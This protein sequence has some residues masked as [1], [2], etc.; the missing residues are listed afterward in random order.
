MEK[1]IKPMAEPKNN[2]KT[3]ISKSRRQY[4]L[5][6]RAVDEEK[7]QGKPRAKNPRIRRSE[8]E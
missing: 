6:K 2:T 1:H 8:Q 4:E 7:E 3:T 5:K